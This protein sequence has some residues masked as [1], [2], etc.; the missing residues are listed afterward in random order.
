MK[1]VGLLVLAGACLLSG[2]GRGPGVGS[3]S[4]L[5]SATISATTL[6]FDGEAVGTAS[7]PQTITLSN[8]GT[9]MLSGV[10]LAASAPFTQ[11]N[12]CGSTLGVG[13]NCVITVTFTPLSAG[14]VNGTVSITDNAIGQPSDY[15][16]SWIWNR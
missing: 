16:T 2:G 11:T 13:A 9:A 15:G 4:G 7:S 3:M 5:P 12:T 10:T 1:T 8:S 14:D 6:A